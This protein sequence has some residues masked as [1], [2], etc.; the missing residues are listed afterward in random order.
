MT[1]PASIKKTMNISES[2]RSAISI[3]DVNAL[4]C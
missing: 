4:K 1:C 2:L 3:N